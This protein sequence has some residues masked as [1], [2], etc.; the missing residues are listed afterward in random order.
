MLHYSIRFTEF[1]WLVSYWVVNKRNFIDH[2]ET[3]SFPQFVAY[4]LLHVKHFEWQRNYHDVA[5]LAFMV[6]WN[7]PRFPNFQEIDRVF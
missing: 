7:T 6:F 1:I 3:N 4:K 5:I 2:N